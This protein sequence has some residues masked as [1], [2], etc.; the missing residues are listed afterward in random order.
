MNKYHKITFLYSLLF[1]ALFSGCEKVVDSDGL[2]S[3]GNKLVVNSIISPERK[4][5]QVEV[6]RSQPILRP[7]N[8]GDG[9]SISAS[10]T[11]SN[12]KKKVAMKYNPES[13]L[14]ELRQLHMPIE[15]GNTYYLKVIDNDKTA[16]AQCT[17]PFATDQI[18]VKE[19]YLNSGYSLK[20]SWEGIP[21]Q[22]NYFYVV[23]QYSADSLGYYTYRY[24][25]NEVLKTAKKDGANLLNISEYLETPKNL[26]RRLNINL[27]S[28][29]ETHYKYLEQ[30]E[31]G[32]NEESPFSEP[33]RLYTNINGGLGL[34]AGFSRAERALEL[35]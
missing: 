31:K 26:P 30:K 6:S 10:V 17:I 2:V 7:S 9:V 35:D 19:T 11:I 32:I 18:T 20:I 4:L 25:Y 21:K 24:I 23:Y 16:T 13:R 3:K 14:Y 34:F 8:T 12:G 28:I 1:S 33:V 29:D 22:E 27:V 5:I 15:E